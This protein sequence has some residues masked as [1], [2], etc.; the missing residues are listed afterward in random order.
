MSSVHF[1]LP[2]LFE[3]SD[4]ARKKEEEIARQAR[5]E[6]TY[7]AAVKVKYCWLVV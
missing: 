5:P 4:N 2:T 6:W 3:S 1:S 7:K